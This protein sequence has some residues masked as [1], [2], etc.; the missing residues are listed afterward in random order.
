M[1][2]WIWAREDFESLFYQFLLI[3][4]LHII[5]AALF[6]QLHSHTLIYV[7]L[8]IQSLVA[9]NHESRPTKEWLMRRVFTKSH[10]KCRA[11][12]GPNGRAQ[13]AHREDYISQFTW[14][15]NSFHKHLRHTR[16]IHIAEK[17][18]RVPMYSRSTDVRTRA[19]EQLYCIRYFSAIWYTGTW[20]STVYSLKDF[21][22]A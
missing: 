2:W 1:L 3:D 7:D 6:C 15:G 10:K 22:N 8:L 18:A 19:R 17:I 21:L 20:C 14:Y 12:F 11:L 5:W 16:Q 4:R 9:L 13:H